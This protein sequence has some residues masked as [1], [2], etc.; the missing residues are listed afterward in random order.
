MSRL[1]LLNLRANKRCQLPTFPAQQYTQWMSIL[2]VLSQMFIENIFQNLFANSTTRYEPYEK[3]FTVFPRTVAWIFSKKSDLAD[4]RR[5][6]NL[7][8]S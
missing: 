1:K 3:S 8:K 2:T 7:F 5:K 4:I 6:L